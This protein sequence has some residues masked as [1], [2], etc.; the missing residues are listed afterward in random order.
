VLISGI[1]SS[2]FDSDTTYEYRVF[3]RLYSAVAAMLW[4][5]Q[6]FRRQQLWFCG[7]SGFLGDGGSGYVWK[8]PALIPCGKMCIPEIM[9]C[10]AWTL[11]GYT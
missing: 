11:M 8:R 9:C 2:G 6:V 7:G 1:W 3:F 5:W 4:W 10:I